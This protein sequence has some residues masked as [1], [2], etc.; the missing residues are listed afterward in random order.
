MT[1]IQAL[2]SALFYLLFLG[3]TVVLAI[4]VGTLGILFGKT[5]LGWILAQYWGNSNL[6][7]LRWV[8]G[9]K[10]DV[11]G[12]ENIPPGPCIFA[13][14]HM[15]DWDIFAILPH[16]NSRPAFIAKK[17][18]M[19]IPFFGWAARSF[20][21]IRIDRSLGG[22]AIPL[23]MQDARGAIAK[24][25]RLV[26]FPEGTRKAPLAPYDYRYG[27]VR[28]YLEL[29]VPVVPVA[30]DSGLYW[31]RK[32]LILW[33]GTARARFLPAIPPGLN[34]E[35]FR[36]RLVSAIEGETNRLVLA[37]YDKGLDRPLAGE[38]GARLRRLADG[39]PPPPVETPSPTIS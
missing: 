32:S 39:S 5:R 17:E 10:T 8:V 14:K 23:M 34:G 36:T 3:Q 20:D 26:I 37:A 11:A 25:C 12:M 21:T 7:F 2:R 13:A 4:I 27:I 9:M 6:W 22:D 35:D 18:L 38:L 16:T 1:I 29:N 33:P 28:M 31:S 19:D 24:G 15:S 30:L